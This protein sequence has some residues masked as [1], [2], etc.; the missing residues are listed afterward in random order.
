MGPC[1]IPQCVLQGEYSSF[2]TPSS[3]GDGEGVLVLVGLMLGLHLGD[4]H[5]L[6]SWLSG[7]IPKE[8]E[9]CPGVR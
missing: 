8:A 1:Q 5:T 9:M 3:H 4:F 7:Q 6:G 2:P